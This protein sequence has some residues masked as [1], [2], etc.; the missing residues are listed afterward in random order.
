MRAPYSPYIKN[1]HESE[2]IEEAKYHLLRMKDSLNEDDIFRY[3]LN[4]F[5]ASTRSVFQ[6]A[7]EEIQHPPTVPKTWY[8]QVVNLSKYVKF[9]KDKRDT[10]IHHKPIETDKNVALENFDTVLIED[11]AIAIEIHDSN[12]G[13]VGS[14]ST[15]NTPQN[16]EIGE[17]GSKISSRW[18]FVDSPVGDPKDKEVVSLCE[19]YLKEAESFVSDGKTNG[20]L[21]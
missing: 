11:D 7:L 12:E 4:A 2:K 18:F 1:M 19:K 21:T 3:E 13:I 6:Y 8:D 16:S 10:V 20:Y 9:F 5:L 15:I 17:S 14:F